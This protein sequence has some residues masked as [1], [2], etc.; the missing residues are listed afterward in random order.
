VNRERELKFS[1]LDAPPPD[2][3]LIDAFRGSG[4]SLQARGLRQQLDAYV[5]TEGGA[6]RA[7][8]VALRRRQVDGARFATLKTL[9]SVAGALHERDELELP[10][11][12]GAAWPEPL[13]QRLERL[14]GSEANALVPALRTELLIR[15]ERSVFVVWQGE[16]RVA[17][18]CFDEVAASTPASEREA[19]FREAELEAAQGVS[20]E[21]LE[22]IAARL[23]RAVTL[24]P[25]GVSKLERAAALLALGAVLDTTA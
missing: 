3:V 4:F 2:E 16:R 10:L 21:L 19:L 6:L 22:A 15:T 11:A 23:E 25:S 24:T 9:G 18:L 7:A 8:G 12:A 20:V 5:D 13:L 14:I 1:L 17:E